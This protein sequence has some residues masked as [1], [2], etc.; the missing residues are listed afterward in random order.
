[1]VVD[2]EDDHYHGVPKRRLSHKDKRP[3]IIN[4]DENPRPVSV[5]APVIVNVPEK[6]HK[7]RP[8]YENYFGERTKHRGESE[9]EHHYH[10]IPVSRPVGPW[11]PPTQ[12]WRVPK[13]D[14]SW[15]IS[16]TRDVSVLESVLTAVI[17][18]ISGGGSKR[19]LLKKF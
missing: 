11:S 7:R 6:T 3:I 1:M 18:V 4:Q 2:S 8:S 9:E 10:Y 15:E 17:E 12:S 16:Y 19:K 14:K 5:V 13:C